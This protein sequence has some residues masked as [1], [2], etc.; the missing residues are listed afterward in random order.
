[1]LESKNPMT[2]SGE[3]ETINE[4]DLKQGRGTSHE[5]NGSMATVLGGWECSSWR[6]GNSKELEGE[7]GMQTQ[8]LIH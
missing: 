6:R 3:G 1:M 7:E 5:Q 2:E 4:R 8:T